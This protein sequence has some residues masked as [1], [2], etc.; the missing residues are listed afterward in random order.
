VA[1]DRPG[2]AAARGKRDRFLPSPF[3]LRPCFPHLAGDLA[4]LAV[5]ERSQA[6]EKSGR[7]SYLI[8]IL[9]GVKDLA[10]QERTFFAPLR[11]TSHPDE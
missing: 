6:H 1:G 10:E 3:A 5:V 2:V 7:N 8:V 4:R 9:S 11:M